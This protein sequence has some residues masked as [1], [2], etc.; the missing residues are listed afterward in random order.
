MVIFNSNNC[1]DHALWAI[2][3]IGGYRCSKDY[4][5]LKQSES[6][7]RAAKELRKIT[8]TNY[9]V[10]FLTLFSMFLLP[11][12]VGLTIDG[13]WTIFES[14]A[15]SPSSGEIGKPGDQTPGSIFEEENDYYQ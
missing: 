8:I 6:G 12:V 10:K 1:H 11:I 4:K 2:Q 7:S 14:F 3:E 5:E 9:W 13:V 15:S